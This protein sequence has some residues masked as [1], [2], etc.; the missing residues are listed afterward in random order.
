MVRDV[1]IFKR[2]MYLLCDVSK[3]TIFQANDS[4]INILNED[5]IEKLGHLAFG[6]MGHHDANG[7]YFGSYYYALLDA[8]TYMAKTK[9]NVD[10]RT[11]TYLSTVN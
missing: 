9:N 6:S 4:L 11:Y 1:M 7:R 5:G 2:K 10:V 8:L 3:S